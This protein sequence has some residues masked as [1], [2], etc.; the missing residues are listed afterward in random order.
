LRPVR[1]CSA[2]GEAI[3]VNSGRPADSSRLPI[4]LIRIQTA[5]VAI[6]MAFFNVFHEKSRDSKHNTNLL[7]RLHELILEDKRTSHVIWPVVA[8]WLS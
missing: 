1:D 7:S 2:R 3:I 4:A 8:R 5:T 6:I